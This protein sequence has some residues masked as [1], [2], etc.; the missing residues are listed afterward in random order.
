MDQTLI[1]ELAREHATPALSI[2]CALDT[3]DAGNDRDPKVLAALEHE[4][5]DRIETQMVGPDA[6]AALRRRVSAA[7]ASIDLAHPTAG[8]AVYVSPET[9]RV[10]SLPRAVE[11]RVLLGNQFALRELIDAAGF[12]LPARVVVLSRELNRCF[13]V[14]D[15]VARER[16]DHGFPLAP[17]IVPDTNTPHRDFPLAEHERDETAKDVF[18]SVHRA[19]Q[20]L[21]RED[22]RDLVLVGDARDLAYWNTVAGSN[23]GVVA[24]VHGNH[25]RDTAAEIARL[26]APALEEHAEA[27]RTAAC[28]RAREAVS[29]TAVAGMV[30]VWTAAQAGRGRLLLV[31]RGYNV[32]ARE[33]SGELRLLDHETRDSFDAVEATI[34]AVARHGG[35][36]EIVPDGALADLG[37]IVLQLRY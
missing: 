21:Q 1:R 8:V 23:N 6:S 30:D 7:I 27:R 2:F 28:A 26:V 9:S 16:R 13:D 3:K 25:E 4:A 14:T 35:E 31:E 29:S 17:P 24:R 10:V 19:V 11:N 32:C 33:V 18:R 37:R 20:A 5:A 36:I 15:G 12:V 34:A 22:P